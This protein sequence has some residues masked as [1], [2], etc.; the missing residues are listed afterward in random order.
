MLP[1]LRA[2]EAVDLDVVVEYPIAPSLPG[3]GGASRA[4]RLYL[5][6]SIAAVVEVKSNAASQWPQAIQTAD[7]LAPLRRTFGSTMTAGG[8]GGTQSEHIPLFVAGYT[9]WRNVD[10]ARR[11]L[12]TAP[13]IA[14][15]LII[16]SGVFV[17]SEQYG[18]INGRGPL[19]LWGLISTLHLITNS[20]QAATN[21]L[22]YAQ[23]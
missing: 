3:V 14:G 11:N 21:P 6:E 1:M 22:R 2:I 17:S 4:T 16:D 20:L 10:A 13:H 15:V 8:F 19:A 18:G 7:Q 9:G 23:S 12:A 5:A